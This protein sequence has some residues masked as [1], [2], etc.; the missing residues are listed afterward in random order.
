MDEPLTYFLGKKYDVLS[1]NSNFNMLFGKK[2]GKLDDRYY[3]TNLETGVEAMFNESLVLKCI[4]LNF[5]GLKGTYS[6]QLPQN[7]H[8][9]MK[10]SDI[11][12]LYGQPNEHGG[13]GF[14]T[15]FGKIPRWDKYKFNGFSIHLQYNDDEEIKIVT[16]E[17]I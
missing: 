13:G 2:T 5:G 8:A 15:L 1:R 14:V 16:L 12:Q 4:F 7:I 10:R 3:L 11:N 6:G 9:S 17:S